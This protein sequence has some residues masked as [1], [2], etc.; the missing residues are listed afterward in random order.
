[1]ISAIKEAFLDDIISKTWM[2]EETKQKAIEKVTKIKQNETFL[3]KFMKLNAIS[4]L[5]INF[6]Q[7]FNTCA[8]DCICAFRLHRW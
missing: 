1:M 3:Q 8:Q 2:D 5:S 4:M 7:F 6:N